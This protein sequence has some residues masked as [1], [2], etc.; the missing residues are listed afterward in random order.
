MHK[1]I[2]IEVK[3]LVE[4]INLLK[5]KIVKLYPSYIEIKESKQL[6]HYFKGEKTN[7]INLFEMFPASF[8]G[9]YEEIENVET[10]IS[11]RTRED[12]GK[13]TLFILKYG[14]DSINGGDRVEIEKPIPTT[15]DKLDNLLNRYGIKIDSK[16]S[17][18]RT[19]YIYE[20]FNLCLDLNSGFGAILEVEKVIEDNLEK[21]DNSKK[22]QAKIACRNMLEE[23]ELEE[24]DKRLLKKMYNYYLQNWK[25]FY[26]KDVYIWDDVEFTKTL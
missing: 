23:L 4:N 16:W 15:I 10:E 1:M 13:G 2:E 24:L 19:E 11:I 18:E 22:I 17:R 26:G 20:D 8:V 21:G 9:L 5:E 12:S 3:A 7:L 14:D 6:N 25:K